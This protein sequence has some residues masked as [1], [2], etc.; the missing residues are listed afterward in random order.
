MK[1]TDIPTL[2]EVLTNDPNALKLSEKD[3]IKYNVHEHPNHETGKIVGG[4]PLLFIH[5]TPLILKKI[6]ALFKI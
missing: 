1:H 4:L 5:C 6:L 3:V 2:L